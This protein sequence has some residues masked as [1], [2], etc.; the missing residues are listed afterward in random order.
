MVVIDNKSFD[1]RH[2]IIYVAKDPLKTGDVL[3]L[4]SEI[5]NFDSRGAH[6]GRGAE[7]PKPNTNLHLHKPPSKKPAIDS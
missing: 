6:E 3:K 5:S 2:A 1:H 4:S 7:I